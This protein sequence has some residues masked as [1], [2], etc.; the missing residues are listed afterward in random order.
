[1]VDMTFKKR[2]EYGVRMAAGIS[3]VH[4]RTHTQTP[5]TTHESVR[6]PV[7]TDNG[8]VSRHRLSTLYKCHIQFVTR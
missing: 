7:R 5:P 4:H 1:M 8:F 2:L 3:D 6:L